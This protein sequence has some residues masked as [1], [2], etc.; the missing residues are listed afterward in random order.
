MN[1]SC[2]IEGCNKR[3]RSSGSEWCEM[4]YYRNRRHGDPTTRIVK[5]YRSF[6]DNV[7]DTIGAKQAWLLGLL[8][9]DGHMVKNSIGVTS[10]DTELIEYARD[11]LNASPTYVYPHGSHAT[12]K[13]LMVTSRRLAE[14]LRELGMH[15]AKSFTI[16][17]P[18]ELPQTHEADFIRGALDGDGWVSL[19]RE[20]PGQQAPDLNVG[21]CGASES[22]MTSVSE[23]LTKEGIRHGWQVQPADQG[24]RKKPMYKVAVIQ[25]DSLR[26][27]YTKLYRSQ[28]VPCC[29]RKY[30]NY[31]TWINTPRARAGRP[32]KSKIAA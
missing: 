14:R 26:L 6:S 3:C 11:I 9:T 21:I 32:S 7:M 16:A 8:W 27:L 31:V 22:F 13:V 1:E 5:A 19:R 28:A 17:W 4:H 25:Q 23:W 10:T 2:S 24:K 12:A 15:E 30:V 18:T 20:R 29:H